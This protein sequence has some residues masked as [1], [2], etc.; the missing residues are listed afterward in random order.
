MTWI[1]VLLISK[2]DQGGKSHEIKHKERL[3]LLLNKSF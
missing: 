3:K 2:K 1:Y